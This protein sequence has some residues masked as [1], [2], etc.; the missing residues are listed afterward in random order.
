MQRMRIKVGNRRISSPHDGWA[1]RCFAEYPY[2][3]GAAPL[4]TSI[5]Y[6]DLDLANS[7]NAFSWSGESFS[8]IF[9]RTAT[10]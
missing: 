3:P 2:D 4:V 1:E 7:R 10:I 9:T 8:G 6:A 5:G